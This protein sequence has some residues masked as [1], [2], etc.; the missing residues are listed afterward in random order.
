MHKAG[1]HKLRLAAQENASP[2]GEL[3]AMALQREFE[4]AL[5]GSGL[6]ERV[7]MGRTDDPDQ[8]VIG[9]CRC[10]DGIMPWEAGMGLER[11]WRSITGAFVWE[12]HSVECTDSMMEFEG[13]V[14]IGDRVN[15]LTVHV[16]AE[17]AV[18][19]DVAS[20]EHAGDAG[21]LPADV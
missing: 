14:T 12:A 7:E 1:F 4:Q 18:V 15:Y 5:S 6:F 10:A 8:M 11:L 13:A 21:R 20:S 16:V 9:L 2:A 17:A 19:E 3:R